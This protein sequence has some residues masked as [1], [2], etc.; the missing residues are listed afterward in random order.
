MS[1]QFQVDTARI[2]AASADLDR[3]GSGLEEHLEAT[4]R[5]IEDLRS[6][7]Q[8]A[9]AAGFTTNAESWVAAQRQMLTALA[10]MRQALARAGQQYADV[11]A[12]NAALFH[13]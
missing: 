11:E 3:R 8:G 4:R 9:A 1:S 7:W 12:A 6:V 5:G 2:Q 10:G 13:G